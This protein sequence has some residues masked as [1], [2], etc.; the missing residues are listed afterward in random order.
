MTTRG[1]LSGR[2][3]SPPTHGSPPTPTQPAR[4][5]PASASGRGGEGHASTAA[6]EATLVVSEG[7]D[8]GFHLYSPLRATSRRLMESIAHFINPPPVNGG[9]LHLRAG[10]GNKSSRMMNTTRL[11]ATTAMTTKHVMLGVPTR[12][13][14]DVFG[15]GMD[16]KQYC[17]GPTCK[18]AG[19]SKL[20]GRGKA[21]AFN[22]ANYGGLFKGPVRPNKAYKG[23]S[24]AAAFLGIHAIKN[25]F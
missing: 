23:P 4:S 1:P 9:G 22:K 16:I 19:T 15:Y 25:F 11:L 12:P 8:H 13:F 10:E 5:S 6:I 17:S 7:E 18:A 14:T 21:A 24:S 2:P 3:P 20:G